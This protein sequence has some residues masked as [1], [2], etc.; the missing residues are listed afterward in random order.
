MAVLLALASATHAM[1]Q[2]GTLMLVTNRASLQAND[3]V[4][5]GQFGGNGSNPPNPF[6]A[7]SQNSSLVTGSDS[8]SSGQDFEITIQ[9]SSWAGN[10]APGDNL[11]WVRRGCC[12][13]PSDSLTLTFSSPIAGGGL[14]IQ[15]NPFNALGTF[16]AKIQAFNGTTPLGSFTV[17]GNSNSNADN[18]APFIGVSSS[19]A[20]IT[21]LVFSTVNP[22]GSNPDFAV[23]KLSLV[24]AP[25]QTQGGLTLVPTR[26]DLGAT[27]YADWGVLQG[28][29]TNPANPFGLL[30]LTFCSART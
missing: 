11:L 30:I 24:A 2:S 15:S 1:G 26:N 17:V 7:L 6:R 14:Q 4:D 12:P 28:A 16:S 27:D 18:S 5:W 19:A 9:S 8:F 10:F 21:S 29:G 13:E 3:S 25:P 22:P 23:N 20:N